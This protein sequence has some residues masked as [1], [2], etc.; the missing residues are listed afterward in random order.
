MNIFPYDLINWLVD[1]FMLLFF[2][3]ISSENDNL[4]VP[5]FF[6]KDLFSFR[7]FR[8]TLGRWWKGQ[9]QR[10]NTNEK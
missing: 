10:I 9:K 3:V 4:F 7:Y 6:W 5:K 1:R 2:S 8:L